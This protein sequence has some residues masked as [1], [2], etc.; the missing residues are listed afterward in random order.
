M[1][2]ISAIIDYENQ[3]NLTDINSL[4][5]SINHRGPDSKGYKKIDNVY[6]GMT[7]LS[8]IDLKL[9]SQP[10]ISNCG[11]YIIVFNG[12]VYNFNELRKKLVSLG[13]LFKSNSDTEVILNGYKYFKENI[14]DHLEGMFSF[15][16]YDN[17]KKEV[18]AARDRLGKKPL[19]I[20]QNNKSVILC[21]EV[22]AINKL[23]K[24]KLNID[25][26]SYWDFLTFRYIPEDS[27]SYI[28]IKKIP[29]GN[30]IKIIN[31][32]I[33]YHS[34]WNINK[35]NK[36]NNLTHDEISTNFSSLFKSSVKKR[37]ISDVPIGVVLS[38]G[39]D[40]AAVLYEASKDKKIESYHVMFSDKS[41]EY[42][43]SEYAKLIANHCNSKLNIIE[44]DENQFINSFINISSITDQPISDLSSIPFK[45]VCDLASRDVKVVLSGEGSDEVLG[46]YGLENVIINLKRLKLLNKNQFF[47][48]VI[49][50]F[51]NNIFNKNI[52]IFNDIGVDIDKWAKYKNY[53]ITNQINQKTKLSFLKNNLNKFYDSHRVTGQLYDL[54]KDHDSLNQILYVI[55]HD[56][57]VEN[58]LMKSDKVSMSSSLEMRCPFLDHKLVEYLF[59]LSG[60]NKIKY[61]NG[62]MHNKYI[63]KNFMKDKIPNEIIFRPKLGF[64]VPAYEFKDSL[65]K[66]FAYD[67]LNSSSNYYHNIFEKDKIINYINYIFNT[68]N[69][70]GY[71][72][73]WS[74][75]TFEMWYKN[76]RV[77][78]I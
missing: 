55:S 51:I 44:V 48:K 23:L 16:I 11:N 26:Q 70:N 13:L 60:N 72:F 46:G 1:C 14:L 28:E 61:M 56:W 67:T 76:Q 69:S 18:F 71:Y 73:I 2:G 64:P 66:E 38:G 8:I 75:L 20:Y 22:Q 57:L 6:L 19:Y 39:L 78:E 62:K 25:K 58:I 53:N 31:K 29:P 42:N 65:S 5:N 47:S 37:L 27:T 12:E 59:N 50:L 54:C 24:N 45:Y 49:K 32:N 63:L 68:K 52:E 4:L 34:Y 74:L 40:S 43:E 3:F 15:I 30:Y 9:G 10:M 17:I 33:E 41:I 35:S 21:S 36:Y 77:N 7:R